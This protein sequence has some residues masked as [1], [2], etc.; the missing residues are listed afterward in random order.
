M[1]RRIENLGPTSTAE[2]SGDWNAAGVAEG[3]LGS[4]LRTLLFL[5][6]YLWPK[7]NAVFRARIIFA[8]VALLLA[9]LISLSVPVL[10][11]AAVNRL[12][13]TTASGQPLP[14][15]ANDNLSAS[16]FIA[17]PVALIVLWGVARVVGP[18]FQQL[19]DALFARVGQNA[20]R[21]IAVNMFRH[22]HNLS[23]RFHLDRQ[24]GGLSRIIERGIKS[25]EFLLRFL[26]FSIFPTFV[27]LA[28]VSAYLTI[29]YDYRYALITAITVV[30]YVW[31]TFS[32][33]EWRVKI[34]REMNRSDTEANTKA[35]DSLLNYETVKYFG[36]ERYETA[37]YDT[38]ME[39]YQN[40]AIRS[41]VSLALVN[42]G[43]SLIFTTGVVALM[44]MAGFDIAAGRMVIGDFVVVNGFMIQLYMPLNMLG[45]VYREIKQALVDMEIMF[46]LLDVPPEVTDEP[47][48]PP[49]DVSGAE[50]RF[51]HVD[52]SYDPRRGVLNDV[53]FTV[54]P[55]KTVAI[56]GPTGAGKS[57]VSRLLY[58]FYDVQSGRVLIDEQDIS[59]VTQDSVRA[60]I[61]IVPQDTVLFNDTIRYNIAYGD[62]DA[63]E[64]SIERAARLA[65]I[66]DFIVS[67]PD[68]YETKVGER[69]LKLSGGEKQRV[70]IART[71]VKNPP[72]LLLDEATSALDSKT[73]SEIQSALRNVSRERTTVVIAHRLST[74]VDADE[75]LV[76]Q[77]GKIVERGSH[78]ALLDK[79][80]IYAD[81]WSRQRETS[82]EP[83]GSP[84]RKSDQ[85]DDTELTPSLED[86]ELE[87][88]K[89]LW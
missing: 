65:Q 55:G 62:P 22:L 8:F 7:D 2:S 30:G 23:L 86:K 1:S 54:P 27:E 57:T 13:G 88:E 66:H 28:M 10:L 67:L 32:I 63:G 39:A 44:V 24:T 53:S 38:A 79:Q 56:V 81:M 59:K 74:V 15:I 25:I 40:A 48:A 12:S 11:G 85:L 4:Q 36:N 18:G 52:F 37:R 29:R 5:A 78:N 83:S 69:G 21:T 70:S 71:I 64:D 34:R 72:I 75:I 51:E 60:T 47:N 77:N 41:Q 46:V 17:V 49:L 6:P 73:E 45:F 84:K 26:L 43:Q 33:T 58:R 31:F 82:S 19:R 80:G 61:G 87:E 42:S 89:D 35:I 3:S 50:I 16:T 76:L 9:K 68:G 14:S 20:Q